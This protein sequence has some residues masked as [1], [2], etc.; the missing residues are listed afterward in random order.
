M[1]HREARQPLRGRG[2]RPGVAAAY[3]LAYRTDPTSAFGGIIAFN[4]ELTGPAARLILE[5]QFVEVILAP[6]VSDEAKSLLAAKGEMRVL[7]TGDLR[8]PVAQLFEYRSVT[9]GLL[10][11]T[12]DSASVR[13]QDLR[14]V[15]KRRTDRGRA[16]ESA[17]RV[18]RR[19][20]CQ[21]ECHRMRQ[22]QGDDRHRC[23]ANEPG[24]ELAR[25]PLSRPGTRVYRCR[26]PPLPRMRSSLSATASTS[27]P[28]SASSPS[29]SQVARSATRR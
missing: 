11:Q 5:R 26:G 20:I 2:G 17:V 21:I 13:P 4:R 23:R 19:E 12:R 29:S 22:G 8:I 1:R 15:T 6:A 28:N 18:A 24:G 16:R 25:S 10:V 27:S 7:E 14:V 9:G 3:G